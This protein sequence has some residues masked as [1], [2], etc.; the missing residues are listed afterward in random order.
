MRRLPP[1]LSASARTHRE[2]D[3]ELP[4]GGIIAILGERFV[5]AHQQSVE[6]MELARTLEGSFRRHGF[7]MCAV[8]RLIRNA[9]LGLGCDAVV[10]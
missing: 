4:F 5:I 6:L 1:H 10:Y 3:D 9:C 2:R 8:M 7:M